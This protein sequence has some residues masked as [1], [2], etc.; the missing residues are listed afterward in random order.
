MLCYYVTESLRNDALKALIS[1]FGS[2]RGFI[3]RGLILLQK[4]NK[5]EMR[6]EIRLR[7]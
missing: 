1:I 5:E 4:M 7:L 3:F 6:G 2:K